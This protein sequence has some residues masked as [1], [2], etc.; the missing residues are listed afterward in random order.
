MIF[1]AKKKNQNQKPE[2]IITQIYNKP[3]LQNTNKR[4]AE[5]TKIL[6]HKIN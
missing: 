2:V 6:Q 3:R 1:P 5:T 4:T